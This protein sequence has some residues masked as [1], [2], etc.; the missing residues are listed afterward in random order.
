MNRAAD[1]MRPAAQLAVL[2]LAA[3]V[4]GTAAQFVSPTRIPWRENW[5]T[6]VQSK[7]LRA[8]LRLADTADTLRIIESG[9]T[10]LLD[11]RSPRDYDS[12]RLPGAL[13]L[14]D[15]RRAILYPE[16]ADLFTP[17]QQVLVYCSGQSCDESLNLCLF[18][19]EHGHTN[20]VLYVGGIHAWK[21]AGL[22]LER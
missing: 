1:R 12:G 3:G 20:L 7:A 13:S 21:E 5:S 6:H 8:G 22:P 11:A 15:S 2:L 4:L 9:T 14:P 16:F 19:R 18:L 17:D 10:L